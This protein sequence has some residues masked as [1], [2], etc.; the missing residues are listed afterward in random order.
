MPSLLLSAYGTPHPQKWGFAGITGAMSAVV[1]LQYIMGV[2]LA[3]FPVN[4]IP[5]LPL[6]PALKDA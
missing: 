2:R 5:E 6:S 3:C 4:A 1:L